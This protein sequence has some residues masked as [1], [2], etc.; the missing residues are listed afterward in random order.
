MISF[1]KYAHRFKIYNALI[2]ATWHLER[3]PTQDEWETEKWDFQ[4]LLYMPFINVL[5]LIQ[6]SFTYINS[7]IHCLFRNRHLVI[8]VNKFY[9]YKVNR[10]IEGINFLDNWQ[11]TAESYTYS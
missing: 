7:N 10:D 1:L 2:K 8:V 4:F 9:N 3:I 6:S 11:E 5:S